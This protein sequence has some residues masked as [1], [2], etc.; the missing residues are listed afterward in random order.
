MFQHNPTT[1][2]IKAE[3]HHSEKFSAD[4]VENEVFSEQF[5]QSSIATDIAQQIPTQQFL[6]EGLSCSAC[7]LKVEK[8]IKH[9]QGVHEVRINLAEN[10]AKVVGGDTTQIIQAIQQ[11]G[12]TADIYWIKLNGMKKFNQLFNIQFSVNSSKLLEL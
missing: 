2:S 1:S 10:I 4:Y 5:T 6:L 9:V 7:V 8:A 11:A 12:Y 3:N